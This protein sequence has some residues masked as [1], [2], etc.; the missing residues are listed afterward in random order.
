MALFMSKLAPFHTNGQEF[1]TDERCFITELVNHADSPDVSLALGRVKVG[2]TTQ[3]HAL[4]VAEIYTIKDGTGLLEVDGETVNLGAGDSVRIPAGQAQRIS[5]TG[6]GDLVFYLT[7][8]PRFTPQ[9]YKNLEDE[10]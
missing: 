5:N 4:G 1:W 2:V 3:L 10:T 6:K 8:R 9:T 7:C